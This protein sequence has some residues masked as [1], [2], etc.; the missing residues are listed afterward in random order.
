MLYTFWHIG[1][2]IAMKIIENINRNVDMSQQ[3]SVN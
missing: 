3:K 1:K 2:F